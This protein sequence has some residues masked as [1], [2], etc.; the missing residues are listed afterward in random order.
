MAHVLDS[1]FPRAK[2]P[3]TPYIPPS[4]DTSSI[5][6]TKP[7]LDVTAV[8][9]TEAVRVL[10]THAEYFTILLQKPVP[11]SPFYPGST[12]YGGIA[13]QVAEVS[14]FSEAA[15]NEIVR[16]QVARK[17]TRLLDQPWQDVP[18]SAVRQSLRQ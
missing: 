4:R 17:R 14:R 1:E 16:F 8:P 18:V 6:R 12:S 10:V 13:A 2:L 7:N 3:F 11:P 15:L 5:F 9:A